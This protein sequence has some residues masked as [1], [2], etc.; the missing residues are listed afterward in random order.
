MSLN[1]WRLIFFCALLATISVARPAGPA[2]AESPRDR[3]FTVT[4]EPVGIFE[5]LHGVHFTDAKNGWAVGKNGTILALRDGGAS[6]GFRSGTD[7]DL[8]AVY[9][10]DARN[11]WAVGVGGTILATQDGGAS[12]KA[13]TSGV[14]EDLNQLYFADARTGWVVGANGT[15]L[16]THDGGASWRQMLERQSGDRYKDIAGV[17]FVDANTGW[18]DGQSGTTAVTHDGGASWEWRTADELVDI[19]FADAQTGWAVGKSGRILAT[20]DGGGTWN[21]QDSGTDK[22]LNGVYFADPLTGWAVGE[23]GAIL[24][25]KDGGARWEAQQSGTS[26]FLAY[27]SFS[28]ARTGWVVGEKGVVLS[29]RDGGANWKPQES[30]TDKSLACV[31]FVEAQ[32]G[33]A[34]GEAGVILATQ[35]GGARWEPQISGTDKLLECVFFVDAR[36]G[37]AVG[38]AGTI[39]ATKDGGARWE[40]Q[41]SDT[42]K[43]LFNV[44]FADA[45]TGWAVGENGT[46]LA[47]K[48]GGAI[49]ESQ[50]S[51]S[52]DFL[53][54]VYFTDA[55]DGWAVALGGAI[56]ATRDGGATWNQ[57]HE[58]SNL[59]GVYFADARTG[60]AVGSGGTIVATRDG[61]MHWRNQASG[62]H[63][64]LFDVRFVD[65]HTGWAVGEYGTILAT[66]DGGTRWEPQ[67]SDTDK[68][69]KRVYFADARNGWAVGDEGTIL[70]TQDGGATWTKP[71]RPDLWNSYF[72]DKRTGWAVGSGGTILATRDGGASWQRQVSGTG[73]SLADVRFAGLNT[74]WVV[75]ADGTILATRD[76]G[77]SWQKQKSG[78]DQGL[79]AAYSIDA[80]NGW[81]VGGEGTILATQDGGASWKA[82]KSGNDLALS[83]VYFADARTGWAVGKKGTILATKDGG[84]IWEAQKSGTD[85]SLG[86]V[87]FANSRIGW[88]MGHNAILATRDGGANWE[89]SKTVSSD[90][91]WSMS[92]ANSWT[93]WLIGHKGTILATRDGGRSWQTQNSGTKEGLTGVRFADADS[94]WIVGDSGAMLHAG[95]PRYAPWVDAAKAEAPAGHLDELDVSF[96]LHNEDGAEIKSLSLM[97]RVGRAEWTPL[98]SPEKLDDTSGRWHVAWNPSVFGIHPGDSVAYQVRLDDGGPALAPFELGSFTYD[99]WF[100]KLWREHQTSVIGAIGS[101]ALLLS[102]AGV[103]ALLLLIAPARLARVGGALGLDDMPKPSGNFGFVLELARK[104]FGHV[105]L[106]YLCR[107][108]RVRRA[109]TERYREGRA[110]LRELGKPA[111]ESFVTEPEVLDAWV[112]PRVPRVIA[113]LDRLELFKQ[114]RIYVELPVRVGERQGG[115]MIERP[116]AEAFREYFGQKRAIVAIVGSGGSGKSTLACA[117]ARWA[118]AD[119]PKERLA[120]HRMLPVFIVEDTTDLV[121]SVTRNLRRMLGEEELP[122]DL[123]CGLLAKQRLLVIV[124]ALSEREA[125]TQRH[126]EQ[127]F[128]EDVPLNAIV[129]TS[130][131]EPMLGA[132]DR[133]TIYP[134]RLDAARVVPFIIG[135]LDRME[136]SET[137]KDGRVQLRLGERILALAEAGGRRTPVTPLLVTL[138]VHGAVDRAA[139]GGSFDDM[140]DAVPEVFVDYL[141]RLNSGGAQGTTPAPEELFIQAAQI[142]ASVSL[143]PNLVPQDFLQQDALDALAKSGTAEQAQ[144]LIDRLAACGL[145]E[146]RPR[147]G[148]PLLRFSLDPAAEYLAA[149]RK[150]FELKAA[151]RSGWQSY[152][153]ELE[154][155][156]G[157]PEG[158]AGY[159]MALATC[160]RAYR[161]D[162]RLPEI[163]FPWEDDRTES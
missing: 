109:W 122:D 8:T 52:V 29:T 142:L 83:G 41:K 84:A 98:G 35:S 153:Q 151:E 95:P 82:R 105:T 46:I 102:Y 114:R 154:R 162:L 13:Q 126:V 118:I 7:K 66:Q 77:A 139:E 39:L 117:L 111:R 44:H 140:P 37:W 4:W 108:P 32:T 28:D 2:P 65:L 113:A 25:T 106:P 55:Q 135:Y 81:A 132:V 146:R 148:R 30:G 68:S 48:D 128:A 12:W 56:L 47:T 94:G 76:G 78:T 101:I 40:P 11:G 6:W 38:D 87:Q 80:D 26:E 150:V 141:R 129:I 24:A 10:A 96:A 79:D 5:D 20:R 110:S 43:H 86:R 125:A 53:T 133:T 119:D 58:L 50:K 74:G 57:Q 9:F 67:K 69:L 63:N 147:G 104:V 91:L 121:K 97:G 33:W 149:I 160:H 3:P 161:H 21:T 34:V 15:V 61:G 14:D 89:I 59:G 103:F 45:R 137:L 127:I 92:F 107:H 18:M 49:W 143:G 158:F 144:T 23:N 64:D 42:D 36:T 19:H 22:H 120:A 75:G 157:Y 70:A 152:L 123:V 1:A 85:I 116:S 124:D 93:G 163:R 155:R 131:T 134:V 136:H 31:H 90:S 16:A 138:F 99:P 72:V 51:G 73:K 88:A 112:Q 54:A 60:W 115:P 27:V 159:L 156:E 100:A 130:R 71:T 62:A 145:I 17:S